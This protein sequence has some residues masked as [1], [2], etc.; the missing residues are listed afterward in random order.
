MH[1]PLC[2]LGFVFGFLTWV[3]GVKHRSSSTQQTE[4]SPQACICLLSIQIIPS[5]VNILGFKISPCCMF[6][7][8]LCFMISCLFYY[9]ISASYPFNISLTYLSLIK[10][11][12]TAFQILLSV[13]F[14][15]V[16]FPSSCFFKIIVPVSSE[17]L[18]NSAF[19]LFLKNLPFP[20]L[21]AL[22]GH[23]KRHGTVPSSLVFCHLH[24]P[25][26]CAFTL[27]SFYCPVSQLTGL[28]S[29]TSIRALI[30]YNLLFL[31]V[32]IF[33]IFRIFNLSI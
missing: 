25:F 19:Q 26:P 31:S 5:D 12:P 1:M 10:P 33:F 7:T 17:L 3:L 28:F 6:S 27:G 29:I 22:Y 32:N 24:I 2:S 8:Y 30:S 9:F 14:G 20:L 13:Y 11:I 15:A 4:S 18:V 23:T 21:S 16:F